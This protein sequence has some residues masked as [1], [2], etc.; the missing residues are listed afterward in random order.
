MSFPILLNQGPPRSLNLSAIALGNALPEHN[1]S[2][3]RGLC[4]NGGRDHHRDERRSANT[5]HNPNPK[6]WAN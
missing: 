4:H 2:E 3:R 5:H 6:E 1:Q